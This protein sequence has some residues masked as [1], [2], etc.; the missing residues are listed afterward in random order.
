M[1]T[2]RSLLRMMALLFAIYVIVSSIGSGFSLVN[3][4]ILVLLACGGWG[5]WPGLFLS[6]GLF[7]FYDA[8]LSLFLGHTGD[9]HGRSGQSREIQRAAEPALFWFTVLCKLLISCL[10]TG[11]VLIAG[12]KEKKQED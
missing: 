12:R 3:G 10:A 2:P 1:P 6:I 9:F 8:L 4:L 7:M 11:H 5:I